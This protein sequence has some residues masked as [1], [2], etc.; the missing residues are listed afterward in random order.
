MKKSL[1]FFAVILLWGKH[2]SAQD[3]VKGSI[4]GG[5]HS[6][7]TQFYGDVNSRIFS[8]KQKGMHYGIH[9]RYNYNSRFSGRFAI[10]VGNIKSDDALSKSKF[11]R[12][13]NINFRTTVAEFGFTGE[14]N[15]LGFSSGSK[16]K[17]PG[18]E[19]IRFSP[20]VFTGFNVYLFTPKSEVNGQYYNVKQLDTE[21]GK[22]YRSINLSIPVGVGV[23]FSPVN[24]WTIGFETGIRK[25]FTD[26]LDGVGG[27]YADYNTVL[28]D[29]GE[30]AAILSDPSRLIGSTT[31]KTGA[32][33]NPTSKDWYLFMGFSITKKLYFKNY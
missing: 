13:R 6:G 3:D 31:Q 9:M 4:E 8:W 24:L 15:I 23:K 20:Y 5:I 14:Y 27:Y 10:T 29:Q 21:L 25:T 18:M 22:N 16:R 28:N 32:R 12:A 26:F 2:C 11:Q 19:R 1:L 17:Y 30:I 33:G 7:I